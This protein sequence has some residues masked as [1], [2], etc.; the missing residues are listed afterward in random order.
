MP[1][2]RNCWY[3]AAWSSELEGSPIEKKIIG[4]RVVLYRTAD[5]DTVAIGA[6][7]P[8]RFAPLARGK[9]VGDQIECA[10]H[11]L[12]FNR[13]GVCVLNQFEP[14]GAPPRASVNSA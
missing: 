7:C 6:R 1:F 14:D 9:V 8:H 3:V 5:G 13:D 4:E 2:L 11:G 12:R 10:Y